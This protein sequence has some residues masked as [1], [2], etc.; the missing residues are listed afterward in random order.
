MD[1]RITADSAFGPNPPDRPRHQPRPLPYALGDG[2]PTTAPVDAEHALNALVWAQGEPHLAADHLGLPSADALLA[3]MALDERVHDQARAVFRFF[4]LTKLLGTI[5]HV[6]EDLLESLPNMDAGAKARLYTSLI[7][8]AEVFTKG[9]AAPP[10]SNNVF[11]MIMR[12]APPHVRASLRVLLSDP[13]E[14]VS[15]DDTPDKAEPAA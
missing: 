10:T 3:V 11:E 15:M 6:Q 1:H 7:Q 12:S 4:Q 9:A 13:A 8:A 14:T 5:Q 2:M